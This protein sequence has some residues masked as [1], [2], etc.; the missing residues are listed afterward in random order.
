MKLHQSMGTGVKKRSMLLMIKNIVGNEME[1]VDRSIEGEKK[2][3]VY[4]LLNAIKNLKKG[5]PEEQQEA[6]TWLLSNKY[7]KIINSFAGI[8]EIFNFEAVKIRNK[9]MEGIEIQPYV[10]ED[11]KPR[12]RTTASLRVIA[13]GESKTIKDWLKDPRCSICRNT[14]MNRIHSL[15]WPSEEA[16]S[17]PP[18]TTGRH[19][20]ILDNN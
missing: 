11:P 9:I 15:K 5:T 14:L 1:N 18:K 19:E 7:S 8:C 12:K 2:L 4:V 10:H 3:W 13:F 6:Y 17:T 20:K 16:I